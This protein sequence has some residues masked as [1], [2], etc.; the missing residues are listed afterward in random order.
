MPSSNYNNNNSYNNPFREPSSSSSNSGDD[1]HS[2]ASS[3]PNMPKKSIA[4][5]NTQNSDDYANHHPKFYLN[6]NET[7]EHFDEEDLGDDYENQMHS[8]QF[9]KDETI[10][11]RHR[12]GTQRHAKG[13]PKNS[14]SHPKRSK[15][16]FNRSQSK[17]SKLTLNQKNDSSDSVED[18]INANSS[19]E[20]DAHKVYFNMQLP[21]DML[22][23]ETGDPIHQYSRNKIRTAKYTPLSFL[24]K[25]LYFQFQN[26][27]N[28]YFLFIVILGVCISIPFYQ[29]KQ[30][31]S[32]NARLL[33]IY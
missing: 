27:A 20:I 17:S 24:P 12:W 8:K 10:M 23:P 19:N 15:S 30:K 6:T 26:V 22:D 16:I 21:Q 2:S 4:F 5:S 32:L 29:E 7:E 9:D 1:Y 18:N 13:R 11:K 25:N 28:I 33:S 3:S 31:K 14:K